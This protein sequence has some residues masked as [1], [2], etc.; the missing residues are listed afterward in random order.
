MCRVCP[1][2]RSEHQPGSCRPCERDRWVGGDAVAQPEGAAAAA[3]FYATDLLQE[4][5]VAN[6]LNDQASALFGSFKMGAAGYLG[7]V[8]IIFTVAI[9]TALT[10]R[11]TVIRTIRDIDLVRSDPSQSDLV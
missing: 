4:M 10:T 5:S 2:K 8:V 7:I 3:A 6:A 9:L 11:M 1:T